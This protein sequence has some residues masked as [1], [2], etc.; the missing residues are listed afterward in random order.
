MDVRERVGRNVR[1]HRL[2][3]GVSQEELAHRCDLDRSYVSGIERG[4]RNPTVVV[5]ERIAKVLGVETMVLLE[6]GD[7]TTTDL[8]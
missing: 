7:R 5:L 3:K 2:D 6:P 8:A 1:R 4:V